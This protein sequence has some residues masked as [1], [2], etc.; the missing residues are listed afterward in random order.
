MN[1]I[2]NFLEAIFSIPM[3]I[4]LGFEEKKKSKKNDINRIPK[5]LTEWRPRQ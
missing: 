2:R 1:N 4:K 3:M 5:G